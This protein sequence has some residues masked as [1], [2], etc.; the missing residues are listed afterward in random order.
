[1]FYI[2]YAVRSLA[3]RRR[4]YRSLFAVCVSAVCVI[5]A[6]V[7]ITDGMLGAL[8]D[9][10]KQYYGGDIQFLGGTD[11]RLDN[12]DALVQTIK[13][14]LPAS[15]RIYNRF[16]YDG[17][18]TSYYFEGTE[19]RSRII[20]GVDFTEEK[21]LFS[22]F[23]F[24]EGSP[25]ARQDH[26]TVLLSAPVAKKLGVHAG[27]S[28]TIFM[29]T[30]YGYNNTMNLVVSGI[31]QDSSLFGMYTSYMDIDALR[32]ISGYPASY[33]N[34]I[35]LYYPDREPTLADVEK[36]QHNLG[37]VL[38]M[39]P[40]PADKQ[41]FYDAFSSGAWK[42]PLYALITLRANRQE[43]SMLTGALN[44]IVLII[45]IP[46]V[47]IVAVGI[48]SSYRVIVIK[49][50]IETGT[51]RALGLRP[52]GVIKLF[53]TESFF[54]LSAGFILGCLLSFI[55]VYIL[56]RFNF[57]FIPAFDIFLTGGRILPFVNPLKLVIVLCIIFVTTLGSVLFT[58]H[59]LVHVSP[60]GALSATV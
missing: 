22:H 13:Q 53:I 46:L 52:S 37:M 31:F 20:K 10:A 23:T 43:L 11:Y 33:V 39:F 18:S 38:N 36:L 59:H 21:E 32:N 12:A 30:I 5:L 50:T 54:L 57:S 51:F 56:S 19:V 35:C 26:D 25:A 17:A 8:Q 47:L 3:E 42:K 40:L 27:D 6:V 29:Q 16:D 24:T 34:R 55:A 48:G 9:K 14:Y 44:I 4:Q 41:Q 45:I 60:V 7:F 49:R 58:L 1:M 28:V 15:V 2:T